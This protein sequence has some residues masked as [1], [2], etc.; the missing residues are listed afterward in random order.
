MSD[1]K[2]IERLVRLAIAASVPI[3]HR[4]VDAD[5]AAAMLDYSTSHFL[6]RIASKDDF[7]KPRDFGGNPRWKATEV[8]GWASVQPVRNLGRRRVVV[9]PKAA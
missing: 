6:Q 8:S 1:D 4:Y 2:E 3:E 7:P 9:G 5:T